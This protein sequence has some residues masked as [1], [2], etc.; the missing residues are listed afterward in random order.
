MPAWELSKS[1]LQ[2]TSERLGRWLSDED[3]ASKLGDLVSVPGPE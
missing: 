3:E 1:L 2:N